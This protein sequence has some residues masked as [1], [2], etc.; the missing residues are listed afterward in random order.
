MASDESNPI[1]HAH[2]ADATPLAALVDTVVRESGL[3]G[4]FRKSRAQEDEERLEN[5]GELVSAAA[6]FLMPIRDDGSPSDTSATPPGTLDHLSA[7][8]ESIALVSDAD[9]I[10]PSKGAVTLM[11][12]HAAKGLEF[13]AVAMAGLEDGLLPH[14]RAR[15]SEEE[16]EDLIRTAEA[17]SPVCN[18]V[19]KPVPVKITRN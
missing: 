11:T 15:T 17:H 4:M 6:E 16:L 13:H 19:C 2:A 12:L 7:F 10:D 3:E 8:L 9:A 1:D 5:L 14:S 18:T